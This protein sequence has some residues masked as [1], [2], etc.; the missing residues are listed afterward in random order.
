MSVGVG[1]LYSLTFPIGLLLIVLPQYV[2]APSSM[3]SCKNCTGIHPKFSSQPRP[4]DQLILTSS[5]FI[6]DLLV[7]VFDY[8]VSAIYYSSCHG[9]RVD[10]R[11]VNECTIPSKSKRRPLKECTSGGA[12]NEGSCIV[13]DSID[14]WMEP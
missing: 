7:P 12:V 6:L 2:N 13:K 1:A 14:D 5:W 11:I 4:G 9:V 3:R 8:S 10:R